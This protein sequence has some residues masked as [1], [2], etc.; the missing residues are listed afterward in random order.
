MGVRPWYMANRMAIRPRTMWASLS[1][2][3]CSRGSPP[4]A[5]SLLVASHTW[6][7]Q[8]RTLLASVLSDVRQRRQA[9][10][11]LDDV[12]VAILPVVEKREIGADVSKRH[13]N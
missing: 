5:C 7:A 2:T 13:G 9:T 12:A 10:P 1:P 4:G 3:K 8:P 11:Q 6:L